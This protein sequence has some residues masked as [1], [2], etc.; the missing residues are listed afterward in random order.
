MD[1]LTN[2]YICDSLTYG[3]HSRF[4]KNGLYFVIDKDTN[5]KSIY[6]GSTKIGGDFV[7]INGGIPENI[8]QGVVYYISEFI[9]DDDASNPYPF[10]GF[11]DGEK[12]IDF[13]KDYSGKQDKLTPGKGIEISEENVI[14]SDIDLSLYKIVSALPT[15]NIDDNKIYIVINTSGEEGN[16]YTEYIHHDEGW[17]ILGEYKAEIPLDEYLKKTE[18]D[19][20]YVAKSTSGTSAISISTSGSFNNYGPNGQAFNAVRSVGTSTQTGYD[21]NAASFGVKMDGTTAFSHKKYDTFIPT[22]GVYTG[23]KNTAV[24]TFS[25]PTGLRYAK[26]TGSGTDVSEDMYRYV[27]IIDSP[28]EEQKVY[29]AKQVDDL[30]KGLQDKIDALEA[31]VK[32]LEG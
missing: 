2:I 12:W 7:I 10:V 9:K 18:A 26:N 3:V 14:S 30:I 22:T 20:K 1:K 11:W 21:I 23:A 28:D 6:R 17:E 24:L 32:A 15:E 29:S 25:G 5:T 16:K 19:K 31:R 27:G 13:H 4:D 8:E